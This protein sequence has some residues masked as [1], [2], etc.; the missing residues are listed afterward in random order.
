[1]PQT[2]INNGDTGL[3]VRNALNTMFNEAYTSFYKISASNILP[4]T[5]TFS[6]NTIVT[7]NSSG[8]FNAGNIT[9]SSITTSA[10]SSFNNINI[11]VLIILILVLNRIEK[12]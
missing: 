4:A 12:N 10:D 7:R 11:E 8:G 1:M 2:T 6:A 5:S 3:S 9:T